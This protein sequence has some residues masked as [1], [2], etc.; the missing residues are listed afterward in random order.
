M[1][2]VGVVDGPVKLL[3]GDVQGDDRLDDLLRPDDQ[4]EQFAGRPGGLAE[5]FE[6]PVG[7]QDRLAQLLLGERDPGPGGLQSGQGLRNLGVD[8]VDSPRH[9]NGGLILRPL[10]LPDQAEVA[11]AEVL[12][13]PDGR[14]VEIGSG[15]VAVQRPMHPRHG[16]PGRQQARRRGGAGQEQRGDE[17]PR[18]LAADVGVRGGQQSPLRCQLGAVGLRDR[19]QRLDRAVVAEQGDLEIGRLDRLQDQVRVEQEDFHQPGAGDSPVAPG[20]LPVLLQAQRLGRRPVVFQGGNQPRRQLP[21]ERDELLGLTRRRLDPPEPPP[22]LLDGEIRLR[23]V[24]D[25]VI[26]GRLNVGPPGSNHPP[27]RQRREDG[28]GGRD[29]QRRPAADEEVIGPF[30]KQ[31]PVENILGVAVVPVVIDAAGQGRQLQGPGLDEQPER[32]LDA[33]RRRRDIQ[34]P[35]PGQLHRRGK[36]DWTAGLAPRRRRDRHRRRTRGRVG[37][38]GRRPR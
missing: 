23:H 16:R 7:R 26:P 32:L 2:D 29:R 8:P 5:P 12:Q 34:G 9:F 10:G 30:L 28:V 31:G 36:V 25:A 17:G 3:V 27:G 6:V 24:E 22:R 14:D 11:E 21:G 20:V 33:G 37:R 15:T 19:D 13:L 38:Q 35:D 4:T 18:L 1:G